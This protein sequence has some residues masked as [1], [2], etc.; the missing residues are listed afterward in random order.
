MRRVQVGDRV[1]VADAPFCGQCYACINDRPDR[2][3]QSGG[4]GVAFEPVARLSNGTPVVGAINAGGYGE[5]MIAPEWFCIPFFDNPTP[6]VE[7][8]MLHETGNLGLSC[9]F[10]S[11]PVV[12]GTDVVVFGC[13]PIGL[14]AVQG[15]RIKGASQIIAIEPI[16]ARREAAMKL[17]ATMVLDPHDYFDK[18]APAYDIRSAVERD[19]LVLK[20]R[21]LC[22]GPTERRLAGGRPNDKN[23]NHAGPNFVV[24]A[25]GGDTYPTKI[26]G[27]DPTGLLPLHQAWAACS[28][29]GHLTTVSVGQRGDFVLPAN[30][31]SN[32]SKNQHSGTHNGQSSLRDLPRYARLVQTG[33][34]NAKALATATFPLDR[35]KDA[36]RQVA[37]RSTVASVIVFA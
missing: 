1:F 12:P 16:P 17:G 14:G 34:F 11:A 20:L 19:P 22:K 15:A 10:N 13:G 33:Q 18:T 35:L 25:V 26:P 4:G 9:V 6:A 30:Q 31:W 7:L 2:C 24:E 37:D 36:Y 32:A 28:S 21:D 5:L 27:P 23:R 8:A 29:V 3:L